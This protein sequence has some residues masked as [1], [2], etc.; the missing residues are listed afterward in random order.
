MGPKEV[1]NTK[2]GR[3]WS[4]PSQSPVCTTFSFAV[5]VTARPY[6]VRFAGAWM[7]A[8]LSPKCLVARQGLE[9]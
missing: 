8:K 6:P 1:A 3:A 5:V 2:R 9:I 4:L 7:F